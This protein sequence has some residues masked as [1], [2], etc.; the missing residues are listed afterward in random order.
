VR[1][2]LPDAEL[3]LVGPLPEDLPA[4]LPA[5]VRSEGRIDRAAPD[6]EERLAALFADASA[7]VLPSRFEPFGTA[8]LE[9]MGWGLACVGTRGCAMPEVIEEGRTGLLAAPGDPASLAD[10]LVGVL[11]DPRLAVAMGTAGRARL[12]AH[13][14]WQRVAERIAAVLAPV[15]A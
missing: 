9:G 6:G 14:T 12:E 5:G 3:V 15:R 2:V 4:V 7:L 8:L 10:A 13:F 1:A 11:A